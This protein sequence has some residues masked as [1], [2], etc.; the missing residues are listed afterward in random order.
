MIH[1]LTRGLYT[2]VVDIRRRV[3]VETAR[4][5]LE[6]DHH[7]LPKI[8]EETAKISFKIISQDTPSY[9]CCVYKERSIVTERVRLAL[10]LPLWEGALKG[11]VYIGIEDA[12]K[13]EK[14]VTSEIVKVIPE[15]CEKCPTKAY[16]V[17]DNCR[18]C[19]AHPCS[20][21]CPV[22][23]I[24][25]DEH[26]AVIDQE[27]CVKCGRCEQACPYNAIL[28]YDRPCAAACGVNAIGSDKIGRALIDYDKCVRCGM[29]IVAC[30]F[31]AIADKSEFVQMLIAMKENRKMFAIIAPSFIGQ[32]GPLAAPGEIISAVKQIGFV[33]VME[34]AYGADVATMQESEEWY[35]KV[36]E[37]KQRFL[38][39]SCCPAWV[40]M[41][42]NNFPD[43]G[44]KI[45][46]SYTPMVGTA[47]F[48]KKEFPDALVTFIGPCTA[49]KAEIL[50]PELAP[51]V[52]FVITFE[53]L[54]S[55]FVAMDID[56][57]DV[58]D[59]HVIQDAS[60]SG[61][62]YAVSGG[63][64]DAV[65]LNVEEFHPGT[66]VKIAKADSLAECRQMLLLAKAGKLDAN[67]LEGMACPGGCVGG[68][69]ILAPIRRTS[70][71][72]KKFSLAS[73]VYPAFLNPKLKQKK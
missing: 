22:D 69:G 59:D 40:D 11:P 56:L 64:A 58:S 23:A 60:G 17:S 66:V 44:E 7:N 57:A 46:D 48:I 19:L 31:G 49:K 24:W 14:I 70:E 35:H 3:F 54:A 52:D 61:R 29:C 50:R 73:E 43:L 26:S 2:D 53:E 72:V 41:A 71:A 15:A 65:R 6:N 10:G 9:R 16:K 8:K 33:E 28:H 67:L 51:F 25:F 45:S 12:L 38:G 18:K 21:V 30:P 1:D 37:E 62:N 47:Q 42:K 13:A 36:V 27:K 63:V 39:T 55:I 32:F 5:I 68:A 34:V 20:L 4:V